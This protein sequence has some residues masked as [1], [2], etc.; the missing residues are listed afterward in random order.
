VKQVAEPTAEGK[1]QIGM[2][3][4]NILSG[5]RTD[6]IFSHLGITSGIFG[7]FKVVPKWVKQR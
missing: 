7:N 2:Y 6:W 3:W 4:K 1:I 5:A